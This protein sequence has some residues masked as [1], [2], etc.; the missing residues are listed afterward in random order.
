MRGIGLP[1]RQFFQ[2][3]ENRTSD[4]GKRNIYDYKAP[5]AASDL[6]HRVGGQWDDSHAPTFRIED[7]FE[8]ALAHHIVV[9]D[10]D[11]DFGHVGETSN[12]FCLCLSANPSSISR[13]L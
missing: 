8:R 4:V 11:S 10:Q 6:R 5:D 7:V 13:L 1:L 9:D 12:R 2:S 3:G